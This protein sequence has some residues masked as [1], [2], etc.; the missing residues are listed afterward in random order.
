MILFKVFKNI[1]NFKIEK[2][3]LLKTYKIYNLTIKVKKNN[4]SKK[5]GTF[6]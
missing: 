3:K 2:F 5:Y 6:N 1:L 4:K